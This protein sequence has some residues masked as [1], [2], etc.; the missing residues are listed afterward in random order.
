MPSPEA[1]PTRSWKNR[2]GRSPP[3]AACTR[4][5]RQLRRRRLIRHPI[6]ITTTSYRGNCDWQRD[7]TS[8]RRRSGGIRGVDSSIGIV[9]RATAAAVRAGLAPRALTATKAAM[10]AMQ[11]I[12]AAPLPMI[13]SSNRV[14]DDT[15]AT[16]RALWVPTT[17]T[18]TD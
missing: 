7:R 10:T 12:I 8:C 11:I 13:T 1:F 18:I 2:A 4:K 14:R 9:R 16:R 6:E 3:T 17:T 5:L 15:R